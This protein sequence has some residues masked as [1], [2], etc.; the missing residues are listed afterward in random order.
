MGEEREIDLLTT[1]KA[2]MVRYRRAVF[3]LSGRYQAGPES[4]ERIHPEKH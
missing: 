3:F 4:N 2:G 1:S